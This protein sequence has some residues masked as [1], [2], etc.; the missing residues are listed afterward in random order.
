MPWSDM[1]LML[2]RS[3]WRETPQN[4]GSR[5]LAAFSIAACWSTGILFQMSRLM[6]TMFE[7]QV[8]FVG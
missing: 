1:V 6:V 8:W 4:S 3:P 2:S 5:S 7:P